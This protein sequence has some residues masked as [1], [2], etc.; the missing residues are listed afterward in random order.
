MKLIVR[1]YIPP[2]LAGILSHDPK[3]FNHWQTRGQGEVLSASSLYNGKCYAPEPYFS[4]LWIAPPPP[5]VTSSPLP[6][7][8]A[9][10]PLLTPFLTIYKA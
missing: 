3:F 4:F 7:H 1:S 5:L 8:S 9:Y 2:L 10:Y 6:H